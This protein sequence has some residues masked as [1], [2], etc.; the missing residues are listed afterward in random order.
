MS[1]G[2]SIQLAPLFSGTSV[3]G[4][5]HVAISGTFSSPGTVCSD[6]QVSLSCPKSRS[7]G[8]ATLDIQTG[9][10][11]AKLATDCDCGTDLVT[12]VVGSPS[13]GCSISSMG[14]IVC[15]VGPQQVLGQVMGHRRWTISLRQFLAAENFGACYKCMAISAAFFALSLLL[16]S[17]GA[18]TDQGVV[19]FMG[20]VAAVAFGSLVGLHGIFFF[21][22][23]K[24]SAVKQPQ[25]R[26][27]CC[28]S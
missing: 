27:S 11:T 15:H 2:C 10:W 14:P 18:V 13:L 5:T 24:K 8:P 17:A 19:T 16:L 22:K 28:G 12:V 7:S 4:A 21:L 1:Q 25:Q 6:L 26:R 20:L 3:H 23:R 9:T